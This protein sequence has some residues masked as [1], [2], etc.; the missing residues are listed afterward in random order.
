MLSH[1]ML[2]TIRYGNDKHH[3][4]LN[5]GL[6]SGGLIGF[7]LGYVIFGVQY[8]NRIRNLDRLLWR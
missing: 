3:K 6:L 7:A 5:E 2:R 1:R 8:K 4:G